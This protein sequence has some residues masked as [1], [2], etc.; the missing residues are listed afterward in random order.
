MSKF[1]HDDF[2]KNYL[3]EV[4][5]LIGTASPG[6]TVRAERREADVWFSPDPK[7][8][9][10]RSLLGVL[11][12]I[13]SH[14]CLLEVFRNAA[15]RSEVRSCV[16]KLFSVFAER[17]RQAKRQQQK[18]IEADLPMLWILVPTASSEFRQRFGF[19]RQAGMLSGLYAGPKDFRS[20]LVVIHQLPKTEGTIWLRMLGRG[21]VQK[22][23]VREFSELGLN[24]PLRAGV[25]D[26][27]ADL[28][29]NLE[30]RRQLNEE[31]EELIMNL[32][33]AYLKKKEE[34]RQEA[35]AEGRVEIALNMLQEGIAVEVIARTTG[36]SIADVEK[37][38]QN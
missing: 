15:S 37:L 18:V 12:E 11:G 20:K 27:L 34:W 29:A 10:N 5:S 28:R 38:A 17:E 32:S 16:S 23:A 9:G 2:A 1:S 6:R 22:R 4:M 3:T 36:L 8:S 7:L 24:H 25:F 33:P 30:S 26:L 19:R 14:D 31:E 21:N 13:G 35:L